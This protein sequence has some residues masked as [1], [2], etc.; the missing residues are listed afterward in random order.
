MRKVVQYAGGSFF[1]AI[2]LLPLLFVIGLHVAQWKA[3]HASKQKLEKSFLQT[4]VLQPQDL[5]WVKKGK[6]L[7]IGGQ[8]FDVKHIAF[9]KG[10]VTITG[11]YDE[12]EMAIE[13]K[14]QTTN[15]P[16]NT[17]LLTL[18]LLMQS[19]IAT[20]IFCHIFLRW[21]RKCCFGRFNPSAYTA[22][23]MQVPCPPPL[24][25]KSLISY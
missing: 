15:L 10:S 2:I 25:I 18:L 19:F 21:Q 14:I 9:N 24:A 4:I 13:R 17:Y 7:R 12:V 23:F 11:L 22:P 5:H 1:G 16:G 6:E 3:Q 8:L 20:D